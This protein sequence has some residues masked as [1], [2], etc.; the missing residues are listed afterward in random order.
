MHAGKWRQADL[1]GFP[2]VQ[3]SLFGTRETLPQKKVGGF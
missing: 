1:W 2:A 3:I